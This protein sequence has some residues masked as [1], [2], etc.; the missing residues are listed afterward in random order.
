MRLTMMTVIGLLLP[1]APAVAEEAITFEAQAGAQVA[2]F[3]GSLE[4]PENR[5]DPDSRL[6]TIGY[7]RFPALEGAD[8]PPIVYLAGGPGG[9]GTGTARGR[10]F[11]LF[12]Q[13]RA[14]GD[15]IALDQRGTGLSSNDLPRCQSSVQVP[16]TEPVSDA[17]YAL[18]Y[19]EAMSECYRFWSESGVDIEGYTTVQ[20][21]EDISDLRE[22]LGA[23]RVALWGIS[24]GSHLAMAALNQIPDEIDRVVIASAEGL[25]QTVK[26]PAQTNAYI[27]R[28]QAAVNTQPE[29]AAAYPDIA[30]LI[31]RVQNRLH[32]EPIMI[33]V[34]SRDGSMRPFLL[35]RRHAQQMLSGLI[36]DPESTVWL[37][38]VYASLDHGDTHFAA[39]LL[40][41]F[42]VSGSISLNPM[43]T[44]MDLASGISPER[45]ALYEAQVG[46]GLAGGYLNFPM[47]QAL[48][49]WSG[50]D[51]GEGFRRGPY[52]DTP[53]LL[54]SGTLDGRTYVG[55]QAEGLAGMTNLTQVIVHNSGHNLFMENDEVHAVI[56]RFM[57][58]EPVGTYDII[59]ELPDFMDLP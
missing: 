7:V 26:L 51:L 6:I 54:L 30:A 14:H 3:Q 49:V 33:D 18:T 56:H 12:L 11:D 21:V 55:P 19:R 28:L 38:G 57:R 36:A 35:Q 16:E 24:Y 2:A 10:R 50:F 40:S 46:E 23:E 44:A 43:S 59:A 34:P 52:G 25:D 1:A 45:L 29:A 20:S 8:G 32:D 41:R 42:D 5:D 4:V 13:M 27:A 31:R 22:H 9:S 15:V 48:G 47:P 53:V 37:L 39:Q 58:G 17:Q